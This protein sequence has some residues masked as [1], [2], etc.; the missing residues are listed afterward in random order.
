MVH[1]QEVA[2]RADHQPLG[3]VGGIARGIGIGFVLIANLV[4]HRPV[5]VALG[6]R[7]AGAR[8]ERLNPILE[9]IRGRWNR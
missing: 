4:A 2:G 9:Q 6:T 1:L 7:R 8:A 3:L 5:T